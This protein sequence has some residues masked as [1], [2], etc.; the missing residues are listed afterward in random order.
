MF[1]VEIVIGHNALMIARRPIAVNNPTLREW[2]A[3]FVPLGRSRTRLA[4]LTR[5]ETDLE[6]GIGMAGGCLIKESRQ[7]CGFES[8]LAGRKCA[9]I[10]AENTFK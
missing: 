2:F 9:K 1:A 4:D 6:K 8:L 10:H 5:V 3:V 7:R